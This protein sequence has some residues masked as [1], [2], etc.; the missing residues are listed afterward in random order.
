MKKSLIIAIL[1]LFS[2]SGFS[3][4][5]KTKTIL[6]GGNIGYQYPLGDFGKQC[7]GGINFRAAAQLLLNPKI[8]VGAEIDFSFLGQGDFWNGNVKGNYNTDYNVGSALLNAFFY[9]NAWDRDFHPY[10]GLGFGWYHYRYKSDFSSATASS[11]SETHKFNLNKI[12]LAPNIGFRYDIS[13]ELS[14]DMNLRCTYIPSIP[15]S[16]TQKDSYGTD[17][18]Y[19]LGF[20]SIMLPELSIGLYYQF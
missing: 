8:G 15:E 10:M 4:Y 6:A 16:V 3:Q 11:N 13:Q 1:L 5:R 12:G 7:K 14:F 2:V 19:Y 18:A 17:Y 20:S 9:F